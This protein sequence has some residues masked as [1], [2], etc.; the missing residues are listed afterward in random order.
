MRIID[1]YG[2]FDNKSVDTARQAQ[3][4]PKS[5]ADDSKAAAP[6]SGGDAVTVSAQAVELAHKAAATADASKVEQLRSA[7]DAGTFKVDYQA[8]AKRIVDGG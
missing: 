4:V 3:A 6:A 2:R 7:I 8:I 5:D 1:T